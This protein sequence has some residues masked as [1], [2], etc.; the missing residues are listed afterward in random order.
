MHGVHKWKEGKLKKKV[1]TPYT[2]DFL[3]ISDEVLEGWEYYLM[4]YN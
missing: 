2:V 3:Q 1:Y 4:G